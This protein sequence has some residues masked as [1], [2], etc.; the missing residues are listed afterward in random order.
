[1]DASPLPIVLL[2]PSGAHNF[3]QL[4]RATQL[5]IDVDPDTLRDAIKMA[6]RGERWRASRSRTAAAASPNAPPQPAVPPQLQVLA[7]AGGS[8][9][10][11]RTTLAINLATALGA[12]APTALVDL[13]C[14][15]PCVAAY[16]NRDPSRN[17]VTLAH[18]VREDP[19]GWGRALEQELQPLHARSPLAVVLCGLPKRELRPSV[20]QS[21]M[22]R[23]VD[24]LGR[25][26]RYVV[27]DMGAELLGLDAPAIVHRA[28]LATAQHVLLVTASDLV[29]LWHARTALAQFERNLG[30]DRERVSLVINRH[31]ARYHHS[32]A[33]IEWHLGATA[34]L[35]I[36]NDYS[37]LQRA[38]AQ[39]TPAVLDASSRAGRA[40]LQ[41]AERIHQDRV[42]LP[43]AEVEPRSR[44]RWQMALPAGLA[45]VVR[46]GGSS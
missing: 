1:L 37:A 40:I 26:Y 34:A 15:S 42:R 36:P 20:T 4:Q 45:S 35:L 22:Q 11:G 25:R 6:A 41:L 38:V 21:V 10:P 12:V 39:Q 9:S 28:A 29:S 3:D 19:R 17:V 8:G 14:A 13:D 23:L 31:D 24:E 30:V 5:P 43:A 32:Q 44:S 18:A 16:L 27:V 2:L 7:I 33:E 46:W